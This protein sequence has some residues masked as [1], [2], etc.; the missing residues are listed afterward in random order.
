MRAATA[1]A[2]VS[3][4]LAGWNSGAFAQ[5]SP[6]GDSG[7]VLGTA[8]NSLTRSHEQKDVVSSPTR[9]LQ[10]NRQ[11]LKAGRAEM[12]S[13]QAAKRAGADSTSGQWKDTL[14]LESANKNLSG[15]TAN[16][17]TGQLQAA[18]D[19]KPQGEKRSSLAAQALKS[20]LS[21]ASAK[22]QLSAERDEV[23]KSR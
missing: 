1:I 15:M 10:V 18:L 22:G 23:R 17:P 6:G 16:R 8:K 20:N 9:A 7:N 3:L 4:S 13:L 14:R 19:R 2:I 5:Q 11:A 12:D 21:K